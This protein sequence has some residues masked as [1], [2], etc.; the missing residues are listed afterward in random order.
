VLSA[1]TSRAACSS[2]LSILAHNLRLLAE[3][4]LPRYNH[5]KVKLYRYRHVGA[6][7]E[8]KNSSYTFLTSALD[9]V[10]GQR[11]APVKGLPVHIG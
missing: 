9:G 2:V 8:R 4:G 11:Q 3:R 7:G 10:N 1:R 6:N 5:N